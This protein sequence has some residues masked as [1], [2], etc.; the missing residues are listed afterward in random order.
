[1]GISRTLLG[2]EKVARPESGITGHGHCAAN[3]HA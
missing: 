3:Y 1:M 2:I